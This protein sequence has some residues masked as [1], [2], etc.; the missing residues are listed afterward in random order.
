MRSHAGMAKQMRGRRLARSASLLP[1]LDLWLVGWF[2]LSVGR[3]CGYMPD[4]SP[5]EARVRTWAGPFEI[6]GGRSDSG[7]C[8]FDSSSVLSS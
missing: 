5:S 4:C 1:E 7:T 2:H 6:C 3:S 8:F